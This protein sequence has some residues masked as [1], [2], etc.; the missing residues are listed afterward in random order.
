MLRVDELFLFLNY[1]TLALK[2]R[3]LAD[4]FGIHQSTVSRI[5]LSWSNFLFSVLG[6]QSIRM[7][8]EKIKE[9]LPPEFKDY[10]D[11][12]VILDCTELTCQTPSFPL[13]QSEV[14]SSYKSHC[15]LKGMIGM[16]PH[17]AVTFVSPLYA[18]SI[19]DK[20][21]LVQSGICKLLS[22]NGGQRLP[23]G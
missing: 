12:V 9:Y 7:S 15:T 23:G 17:G 13:L 21:L 3:D 8:P 1:L 19:S 4:R 10:A 22:Y 14:Y 20:Q 5:V 16:A 6:S 18:G 11:T 2:Q